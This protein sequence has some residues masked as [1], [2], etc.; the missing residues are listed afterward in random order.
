MQ[1]YGK[2][3]FSDRVLTSTEE[4]IHSFLLLD[5]QP[6]QEKNLC[7]E[8]AAITRCKNQLCLQINASEINCL[9]IDASFDLTT[10]NPSNIIN[11]NTA[12][13]RV[14]SIA[15]K[16]DSPVAKQRKPFFRRISTKI[17]L[18]MFSFCVVLGVNRIH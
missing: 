7:M 12:N 15:D 14:P 16:T 1:I 6:M 10:L 4:N 11:S 9:S 8:N 5:Q 2:Y 18:S 17:I 13:Q 3:R